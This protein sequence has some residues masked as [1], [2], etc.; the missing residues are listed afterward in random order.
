MSHPPSV[1][2]KYITAYFSEPDRL[3]R[4]EQITRIAQETGRSRDYIKKF[5]NQNKKGIVDKPEPDIKE[6]ITSDISSRTKDAKIKEYKR[7][8]EWLLAEYELSERR[9]EQALSIKEPVD[10]I[11][12]EPEYSGTRNEATAKILLSDWHFEERVDP[13]TIN[14]INEYNLK[15]AEFRWFKCIQ[16]S[17]KLVHKERASVDI[18]HLYLWLGGDFITGY[19]HEELMESNYLS[20]TEATRFAKKMI[21]SAIEFYVQYG[22]FNRI[23]IV[24]N[25]G[26]HG[27]TNVKKKISTNYKNSYEWMMYH[28]VA[29]YF[30]NNKNIIFNI[31][32]GIYAYTQIYTFTNRSFHGD[33]VKYQGGIGGLTI[34]LIKAIQRMDQQMKADY[35]DM[36]HYHQLWD[37]TRNCTVNGSGIGYNAYAQSIGATPEEPMQ[38]LRIIDKKYGMTTRLPIFCK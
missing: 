21:I 13:S 22:K 15:I 19:I 25:I 16:N 11:I 28:D 36:G 26:N 20:P 18:N 6:S 35:N 37:A 5:F 1:L 30:K 27:R 29:D 10:I 4:G 8:Y 33:F 9:Y 12:I 2:R 38:G 24:C 23:T 34:P 3:L 7:K 17:L 31:P 32:N 14:N